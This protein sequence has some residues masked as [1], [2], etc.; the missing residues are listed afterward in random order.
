MLALGLREAV[1]NVL[2][3]ASANRVE[4]ELSARDSGLCLAISDDGRGG[5]TTPGNGLAGMRERLATIGG[6]LDI[7]SPAGGGTRLWLKLPPA[8]LAGPSP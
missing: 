8:A 7:D 3:H 2:R 5:A 6:S 1:T 4:V